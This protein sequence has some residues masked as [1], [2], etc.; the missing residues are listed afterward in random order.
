VA[1]SSHEDLGSS[2]IEGFTVTGTRLSYTIPAGE[3]GNDKPMV[4]TSERWFSADLGI[5]LL[6]K[7]ESPE[8]GQHTRKLVNIRVGD[9]DPLLFQIPP[10]YTVRDQPSQR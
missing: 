10:D 5:D 4:T 6:S 3:R 7:S 1:R 8:T 2:T 9:P